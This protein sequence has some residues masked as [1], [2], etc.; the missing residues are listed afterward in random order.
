[1]RFF[2]FCLWGAR[3]V[4]PSARRPRAPGPRLADAAPTPLSGLV[5]SNILT[6]YL[7]YLSKQ[8][9]NK[10]KM[11][12]SALKAVFNQALI[13]PLI[14]GLFIVFS[15]TILG[16]ERDPD[17]IT[18]KAP[19]PARSRR[20]QPPART[21][22][23]LTRDARGAVG[24]GPRADVEGE[25]GLLARLRHA[26]A[27]A[28]EPRCPARWRARRRAPLTPRPSLRV[29]ADAGRKASALQHGL[30]HRVPDPYLAHGLSAAARRLV[31]H[32][33]PR[34]CAAS[35]RRPRRAPQC[36][37]DHRPPHGA[38]RAPP[39]PGMRHQ[40]G[41]QPHCPCMPLTPRRDP[42]PLAPRPHGASSRPSSVEPPRVPRR[43][44]EIAFETLTFRSAR[45]RSYTDHCVTAAT[46]ANAARRRR[47]SNA[48]SAQPLTSPD[49]SVLSLRDLL[50]LSE[51]R[52]TSNEALALHAR[53][54]MLTSED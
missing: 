30:G 48:A 8:S 11:V 23:S 18:N 15:T 45:P 42:P 31:T 26:H 27:L 24:H 37:S 12:D 50:T 14:V 21:R 52:L 34:A 38:R 19:M 53:A 13:S 17:A 32:Q 33:A 49:G 20:S 25:R 7:T 29:A 43:E 5:L 9:F 47:S 36:S 22:A 28:G 3:S 40:Y 41:T 54:L 6:K 16:G 10:N 1:M 46:V 2:A 51:L 4:A 44:S 39:L 35:R